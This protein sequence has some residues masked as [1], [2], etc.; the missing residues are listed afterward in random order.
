M[1][2]PLR[3]AL[4][5]FDPFEAAIAQQ[6]ADFAR[7]TGCT[8]RLD[9][10]PLDLNPL[11]AALFARRELLT[12]QW[13]IAFLPTDWIAEAQ[14][15]GLVEDLRPWLARQPISGFP[16]AWSPSLL[17]L[18][19]FAGGL[20]GMPYHDGPQCL[21]YR[22]DLLSAAGLEVPTTWAAFHTAARRLHDP[23]RGVHGTVLGLFPDGH[24]SFYDFC[25]QIWSRG[26]APF[27]AAGRPQFATAEA[28]AALDFLRALARDADA[29]APGLRDIDSVRSGLMFCEGRV[30]LMAN[31]FGFAALGETWDES[32]VAGKVDIAPLPAGPGGESISL[33]VFWML[34]IAAGSAQKP[35]AWDFL[36]HCASA[37]MDRLTTLAGGVGVRRSTWDDPEVNRRVPY[38]HKLGLLHARARTL[39]ANPRQAQVAEAVDAMMAEAHGTHRPS[40]AL[41]EAAQARVAAI[42]A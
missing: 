37:P 22:T 5:R 8:A 35:L 6:F 23:A 21:I 29:V 24:N 15:L 2:A 33:N 41:L 42:L 17:G 19:D 20:W 13:D 38:S 9:A 39:P 28:V 36:R 40:A 3:V 34:A 26:G 30:A 27:D 31:W 32:H 10:V 16:D 7:N 4:R 12:P 11:H 25:V 18:Q 14:A 1:T